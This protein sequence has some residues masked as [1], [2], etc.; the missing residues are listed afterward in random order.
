MIGWTLVTRMFS[1]FLFTLKFLTLHFFRFNF[2]EMLIF[3][4]TGCFGMLKSL[5][6]I[7]KNFNLRNSYSKSDVSEILPYKSS[8]DL[9]MQDLLCVAVNTVGATRGRHN[10]FISVPSFLISVGTVLYVFGNMSNLK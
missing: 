9:M 4:Y 7:L 3:F 10:K 2:F 6:L 8:N 5:I 1:L